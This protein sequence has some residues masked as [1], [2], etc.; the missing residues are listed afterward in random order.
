MNLDNSTG[1]DVFNELK[2]ISPEFSAILASG[3]FLEDDKQNYIDMGFN[4]V[5]SKP[6][7]LAEL[8]RIIKEYVQV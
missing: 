3:M 4:E 7:N 6:Y 2:G 1:I 8:K 5:I